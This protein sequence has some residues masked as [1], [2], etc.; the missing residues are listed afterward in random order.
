VE[1]T[2]GLNMIG[3]PLTLQAALVYCGS[4]SVSKYFR[5]LWLPH[6]PNFTTPDIFLWGFLKEELYSNNPQR[7]E[8]LK[9]STEQTVANIFPET[10]HKVATK[11]K[12]AR[13]SGCSSS[14]RCYMFSESAVNLFCKL[15]LTATENPR[16]LVTLVS[17]KLT[18]AL[19][20]RLV[21]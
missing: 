15:L 13:N 2:A 4:S 14:E 8:K 1:A 6:S 9:Q 7:L 16:F 3:R 11:S 19:P 17:P 12:N 18:N 20:V 21:F 5:D 10:L